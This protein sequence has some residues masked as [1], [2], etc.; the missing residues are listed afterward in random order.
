MANGVREYSLN[1]ITL[2][3][4]HDKDDDEKTLQDTVANALAQIENRKYEAVL[5]E[6]GIPKEKILA[7]TN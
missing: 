2:F 7:S 3:K 5:L 1:I 6:K 4:V